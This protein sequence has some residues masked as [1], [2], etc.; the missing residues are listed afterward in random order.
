MP[1][2]LTP[3]YRRAEERFRGARSPEERLAA[4]EE[5]LRVIPKHK[6]TDHMQ[7]DLKRRIAQL[8]KE[9]M[10]KGGRGG[11]SYV[12]PREGAGQVA[13]VGLPNSGKSSLVRALTHATP[14]VGDYPFTTREPVPGM[15][16]FED[17]AFQ[18][19]DL[20]PVSTEHVEP[21]VFDLV[22]HA[23]LAWLV[24]DGRTAPEDVDAAV[25]LLASR[26]LRLVPA[27]P[28]AARHAA[29]ETDTQR[30][31]IVVV[32]G[33]DRP[34]VAASLDVIDDLLERRWPLAAV[35]SVTGEGLDALR[36][37]T[38]QAFD[39]IRVYTKQPGKPPDRSAPFTLPRGATVG[40][41]AE[42]IHK[43]LLQEMAFARVWGTSAF[44]G[45]A[46]Q[47]EHVLAEG[48]VVELH[49]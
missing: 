34:E 30:Q 26:H 16:R 14:A 27:T 46:V 23:D 44:D 15:M 7:A 39:I 21:W 47:R 29:S 28:G 9:S 1:A 25:G 6:G 8:R 5:M 3:E 36:A 18:L 37:R 42:R 33:V 38:F 48:D 31:A 20:P 4:L 24:A 17:V 22:R 43:D 12:I 19:V 35:S 45:Q 41:L 2:N 49:T 10:K 40:D 32:T 13:L 11:F